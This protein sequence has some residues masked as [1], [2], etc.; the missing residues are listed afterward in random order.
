MICFTDLKVAKLVNDT[1]IFISEMIEIKIIFFFNLTK[2]GLL[3]ETKHIIL[4]IMDTEANSKN[5]STLKLD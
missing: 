4:S 2:N 5:C 3:N 1:Y